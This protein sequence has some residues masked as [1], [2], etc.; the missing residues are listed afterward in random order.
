[1]SPE[2]FILLSG[3][4]TFGVPLALA[5]MEL[6]ALRRDGGGFGKGGRERDTPPAPDPAGTR[7]L[8]E[9]LIPKPLPVATVR[10]REREHA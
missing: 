5:V 3:A 10:L 1:M 9:C 2:M 4:L 8:P 6:L 7:P